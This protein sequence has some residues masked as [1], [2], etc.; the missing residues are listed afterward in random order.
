MELMLLK[1]VPIFSGLNDRQIQHIAEYCVT[2]RYV[3]DQLILVE[4]EIGKTLFIIYKGRVKVT[5]TSEDGREVILSILESG[6]IF[7]EMSILDGKARSASVTAIENSE[8]ILLRRGDF[9]HILEEYPQIAI[10]LLKEL[11]GRIRKSDTQITSLS[12]QDAMGKVAS[13]LILLADEIGKHREGKIIISRI[14]LQQDLAN[15]AGT[16]R[17]TISR[18]FKAME[19]K[20]Y[21]EREGRKLKILDLEGLKAC[22]A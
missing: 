8:I 4:E 10:A 19:S 11:A 5:R 14:P 16:S 2:K 6:D 20:G 9:L 12:L 3:K 17:E 7:G 18:V 1:R 22:G 15:M 21:I 13:T